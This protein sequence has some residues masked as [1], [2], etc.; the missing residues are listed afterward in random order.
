M[1]IIIKVVFSRNAGNNA[2]SKYA[3]PFCLYHLKILIFLVLNLFQRW[4]K[5][6]RF[7]ISPSG[8]YVVYVYLRLCKWI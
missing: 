7:Y 3:I 5:N 8:I 6:V 2:L 4:T 1:A